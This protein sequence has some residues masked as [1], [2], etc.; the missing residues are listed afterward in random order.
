[1]RAASRL[2][3]IIAVGVA[4]IWGVSSWLGL[5]LTDFGH[6][7]QAHNA[8][9]IDGEMVRVPSAEGPAQRQ[10]PAVPVTT[11]G[12]YAFMFDEEAEPVR[13]DPCRPLAWVL[14]PTGMPDAAEA[15]VHEAVDSVQQATGLK[16]EYQGTTS[17]VASFDRPLIQ[18]RY[19]DQFA[20]IIIGFADETAVRQLAGSVTGI[21]GSSS[22]YGAYGDQQFL[23]SGTVILDAD[24]IGAILGSSIGVAIAQAV[25]Q[26]EV[27]H[28]VGLAHVEDGT[29]LMNAS[30][31]RITEWGPGDRAG[32][33]I[34]GDGPC[35]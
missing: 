6:L 17:E 24:D 9:R 19:G 26:H 7:G 1:M 35:E 4:L 30:N 29:E 23:H 15:L 20:P 14:N 3:V 11:A 22:V 10:L 8:V 31:T 34:A 16:F 13:Y 33:A 2:L 18:E 21:G 28:V 32:L 25:I 5:T 12:E 27:G